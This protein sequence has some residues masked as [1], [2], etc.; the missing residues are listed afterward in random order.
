MAGFGGGRKSASQPIEGGILRGN[1]LS[2][3]KDPPSAESSRN[4]STSRLSTHNA[5]AA[6]QLPVRPTLLTQAL[7]A[8]Q[9][10]LLALPSFLPS[11]VVLVILVHTRDGRLQSPVHEPAGFLMGNPCSSSRLMRK[12]VY[13]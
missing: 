2:L 6:G 12:G 3:S 7:R 11:L 9:P 1:I 8:Y 5:A 10:D 4:Q 13:V